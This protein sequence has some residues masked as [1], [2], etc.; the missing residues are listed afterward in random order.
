MF[1]VNS[2]EYEICTD[3]TRTECILKCRNCVHNEIYNQDKWHCLHI[4]AIFNGCHYGI[5]C[6][7]LYLIETPFNTD[8]SARLAHLFAFFIYILKLKTQWSLLS[9]RGT[10]IVD[11]TSNFFVLCTNMN[12][13]LYICI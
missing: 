7:S 10:S 4:V 5:L 1:M 9:G 2:H 11:L 3:H 8:V 13:Y 12:V 6:L